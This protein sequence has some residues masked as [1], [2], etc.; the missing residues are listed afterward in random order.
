MTILT[1]TE[2][3]TH[4]ETDL[5]DPA[6]TRLASAAEQLIIREAGDTTALTEV[7]NEENF[8]AGRERILYLARTTS[9]IASIKERDHFDDA[10]ITLSSDDYRQEAGRNLIRLREGTNPRQFWASHVEAIY[11]PDTDSDL[12]ELVQIN[13]V[14]LAVMY[15]GAQREEEGDFEFWHLDHATETRKLL[16]LLNNSKNRMPLV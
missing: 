6:L 2:L 7:F 11:T 8:P 1:A 4:V 15:S 5:A 13:L 12:R 3:R 16:A 9:S 10:Q 14:K